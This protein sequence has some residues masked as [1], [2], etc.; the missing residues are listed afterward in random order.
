MLTVVIAAMTLTVSSCQYIIG[1]RNAQMGEKLCVE[2]VSF[3]SSQIIVH[4]RNIGHGSLTLEQALVNEQLYTIDR[5]VLPDPVANPTA[6]ATIV[7]IQG[8]FSKGEY[9]ISFIS[10]LNKDLG[11]IEVTYS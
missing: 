9:R 5:V 6:Q 10:I 8:N 11:N 7:T 3:S 2:K 4:V 1:T